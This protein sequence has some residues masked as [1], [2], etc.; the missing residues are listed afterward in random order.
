M[1]KK[2]HE[3]KTMKRENKNSHHHRIDS[4]FEQIFLNQGKKD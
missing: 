2:S 1:G 3:F 4:L